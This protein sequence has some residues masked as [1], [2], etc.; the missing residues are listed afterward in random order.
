MGI[1]HEILL[2]LTIAILVIC[3]IV[4]VQILTHNK[5]DKSM[6]KLTKGYKTGVAQPVWKCCRQIRLSTPNKLGEI[7]EG[8][9]TLT[10]EYEYWMC[11]KVT[12]NFNDNIMQRIYK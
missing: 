9:N 6:S 10:D 3:F 2:V 5:E 7:Y 4:M 12:M 1:F 8:L 11:I